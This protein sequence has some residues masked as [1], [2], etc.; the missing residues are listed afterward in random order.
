MIGKLTLITI[1]S[2]AKSEPSLLVDKSE[3][4]IPSDDVLSFEAGFVD[5]II[6]PPAEAEVHKIDAPLVMQVPLSLAEVEETLYDL[7]W[8]RISIIDLL[9]EMPHDTDFTSE[10]A[11]L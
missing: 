8:D 3:R 4:S 6:S 10:P 2:A 11:F 7:S 9:L 1:A 5:E